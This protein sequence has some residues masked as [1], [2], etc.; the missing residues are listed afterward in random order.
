[1]EAAKAAKAAEEAEARLEQTRAAEALMA[2]AAKERA[3]AEAKSQV[4][5]HGQLKEAVRRV[6]WQRADRPLDAIAHL[7]LRQGRSDETANADD[8]HE[9]MVRRNVFPPHGLLVAVDCVKAAETEN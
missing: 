3:A 6:V 9:G 8:T 5:M 4:G 2:R 1:M 7:M